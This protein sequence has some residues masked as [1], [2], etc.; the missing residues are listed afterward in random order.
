MMRNKEIKNSERPWGKYFILDETPLY[1][2]KR[3]EVDVNGRLSYQYHEKRSET[4][5]VIHG[6]G[7]VT[8]DGKTK[9]IG[10]GDVL[11]IPQKSKHRIE[12][13]GHEKLIF[14]EV[15]MGIYFG[16]DDIVRI[17]D[18]YNRE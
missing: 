17:E 3:I 12:N 13:I 4:W 8:I 10:K 11:T 18:D 7:I 16:E 2:I 6:E 14:I 5:V 9:K 15:Q 1:K